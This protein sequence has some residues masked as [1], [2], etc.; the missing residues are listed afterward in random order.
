MMTTNA[1][2]CLAMSDLPY[3]DRIRHSLWGY[4]ELTGR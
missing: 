3:L 4:V 2:L 1:P